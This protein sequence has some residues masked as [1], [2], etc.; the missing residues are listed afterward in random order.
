[1]AGLAPR[2]RS[3]G[4]VSRRANFMELSLSNVSV[5]SLAGTRLFFGA[6]PPL[7]GGGGG[8]E[9]PHPSGPLLPSPSPMSGGP[10]GDEGDQQ[11]DMFYCRSCR[12]CVGPAR[13]EVPYHGTKLPL[14]PSGGGG[15]GRR[16]PG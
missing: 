2:A 6:S 11:D 3:A 10:P 1:M 12:R 4:M 7:L 14:P 16:G 8:G 5:G 9:N 13:A 15:A